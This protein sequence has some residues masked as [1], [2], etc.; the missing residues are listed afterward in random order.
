MTQDAHYF[1]V[2]LFLISTVALSVAAVIWLGATAFLE[3]SALVETCFDESVQG[4]EI[5]APVKFRGIEIGSVVAIE[6]AD[7][8]YRSE[9]SERE[10]D[11]FGR[12]IVVTMRITAPQ[13][14]E[15]RTSR[16]KQQRID[17]AV[18]RGFRVRL[19]LLGLS[20]QAFVNADFVD[21][22]LWPV[23]DLSWRPRY[24]Y[25][26]SAPSSLP[27]IVESAGH[28]FASL[29]ASDLI[30]N[31]DKLLF[32]L[33]ER[34]SSPDI[35]RL[36]SAASD[37]A[38]SFARTSDDLNGLLTDPELRAIPGELSGASGSLRRLA[39][40]LEGDLPTILEHLRII[41]ER[42]QGL[43]ESEDLRKIVANTETLTADLHVVAR[44][45]PPVLEDL[46]RVLRRVD[47]VAAGAEGRT[48]GLLG[49]LQRLIGNLERLSAQLRANT[50]QELFGNPPPK[51]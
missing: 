19:N 50:S 45:L 41:A 49:D 38:A 5:G 18:E 23:L 30:E 14:F 31:L 40:E 16:L 6:S 43:L 26:P 47:R 39:A 37:A 44:E 24:S 25:V 10:Q 9:L 36:I 8:V 13:F 34:L 27:R 46:Q 33:E 28:F 3:S 22:E 1:R 29:G 11:E 35:P 17:A 32:T 2:G 15:E 4:L 51:K 42:M 7:D 48:D 12:Y 20:G 21:P